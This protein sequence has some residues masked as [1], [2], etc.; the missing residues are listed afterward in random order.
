MPA[1]H[2]DLFLRRSGKVEWFGE[3][4]Q[5][6]IHSRVDRSCPVILEGVLALDAVAEIGCTPGFLIVVEGVGGIS[7]APHIAAYRER[8][9]PHVRADFTIEGHSE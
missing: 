6:V 4:L 8:Q 9:K 3:E 7:L 1:V 5:R 2:L